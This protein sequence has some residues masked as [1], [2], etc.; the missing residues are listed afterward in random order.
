MAKTIKE[1]LAKLAKISNSEFWDKARAFSPNF[2]SHTA[3]GTA[4]EFTEKGFEAIQLSGT[5]TLNEFFE[6]SMRVSFQ[7]LN[8]SRAR[9]PLADKG[10]IQVYDTPNGGFIQRMAVNS[11]KPVSPAYKGLRNGDSVDPFVVR[12][13]EI[14]E[15]FFEMNFDYQNLVTVQEHQMRTMFINEYGMGQLLSGILE[16]LANGYSVQEYVNTK[17]AINTAINSTDIKDTQVI[18][19]TG[20]SDTPSKAE[21]TEF[22]LALKNIATRLETTAQTGA[23]NE[24]GFETV[25]A[26]EDHVLLLRAGVRGAIDTG[27]MVGAFNPDYLSLPFE[28]IE[29]DDF[30]GLVPYSANN[31]E[32]KPVYDNLGERVGY[33]PASATTDGPAYLD[34]STWYVDISSVKTAVII[35]PAS[36][37]DPN[38]NVLAVLMQ[39]GA[40]FET[41][42]NPYTVQPI[43]N[44]RGLY[45]NYIANRP[46]T[47]IHYDKLY[48]VIKVEKGDGSIADVTDVRIVNTDTEPINSFVTNTGDDPIPTIAVT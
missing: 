1:G 9:N 8:V 38:A 35:E 43:Y 12:K 28:V 39:K 19:V 37:I 46:N 30:G 13:P 33:I 31:A 15:R 23:F 6:I 7:I 11:L 26:P 3:E 32:L 20:W 24:L 27:L 4:I 10:L 17:E 41:A 5:Q 48:N 45:T 44:P 21:M 29:V 14:S 40:I 47:G 36:W 16:G 18:T 2:K 22:V 42:Q 34:G 25:V